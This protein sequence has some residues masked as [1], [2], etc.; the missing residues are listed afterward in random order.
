M[1]TARYAHPDHLGYRI[2]A[3]TTHA[4]LLPGFM[5]TPHEMRPLADALAAAGVSARSVLLPGFGP[6]YARLAASSAE[7]W[8]AAAAAAWREERDAASRAVLIGFSMGAAIAA[9]VAA[10]GG[11]PDELILLAPHIRMAD[12]RA[13]AL[14]LLKLLMR[15]FKP[16]A[17]ADFNDPGIRSTFSEMAPDADLDDPAVQRQLREETSI[18]TRALD[19]LRRAGVIANREAP[20]V[21]APALIVQGEQDQTSLPAFSRE[22]AR[23]LGGPH[24]YQPVPGGHMLVDPAHP[25][26]EITREAVVRAAAGE[27]AP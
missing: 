21:S 10:R 12:R 25:G 7:D 3:G 8:I 17:N 2:S 11:A 22:F 24:R 16:F 4:L 1:A 23:R 27:H 5:G 14:P 20:R 18:P 6:D 9:A 15:E 13:V 19:E 26:W